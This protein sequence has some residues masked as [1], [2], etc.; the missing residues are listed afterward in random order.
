[1][2]KEILY[3]TPQVSPGDLNKMEKTLGNRFTNI[4]KKFG[5][6]LGASLLGGGVAG[7][8]LG[9]I[10]KILN[11]LKDVQEAIDKTLKQGDDV[12]TNAKQFGTTAGKLFKLQGLAKSTGL[13]AGSLDILITKFQGAVA[14]AAQDP[15]KDTSVRKYVGQTDSADAF[16]NFIQALQKMDKTQQLLVQTEVFGE[17]QILKMADFLQTDFA[18]QTKLIG[19]KSADSYTPSIEKMGALNDLKDALAV[20][21]E[22][23]DFVNK[24]KI[25]NSGMVTTAQNTINL[26]KTRE[27]QQIAAYQSLAT[28]TD[29]TTKMLTFLEQGYKLLPVVIQKIES[30]SNS[31]TE[32]VKKLTNSPMVRG[33]R[34][35]FGGKDE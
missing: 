7:V 28:I 21:G 12:V 8:A 10:D 1:M 22:M 18:S 33:I 27:N 9:F 19:A 25:I 13:D 11:P 30:V 5:K 23:I 24:S 6:G 3:L 17:K 15:K 16:F 26:N 2:Y 4:A 35:F 31:V 29:T 34:G 32:A 20:K 14:E